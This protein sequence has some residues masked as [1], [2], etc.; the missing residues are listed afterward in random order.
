M[1]RLSSSWIFFYRFNTIPIKIS[2]D[3]LLI[4]RSSSYNLCGNAKK[5]EEPKKSCAR[6]I[7]HLH[8]MTSKFHM[9]S[10]RLSYSNYESMVLT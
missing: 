8:Y 9:S 2:V 3:F 10:N 6:R 5:L 1:G 4:S 7:K